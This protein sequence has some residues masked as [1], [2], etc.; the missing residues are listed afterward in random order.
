[1]PDNAKRDLLEWSTTRDAAQDLGTIL[2]NEVDYKA[3]LNPDPNII[4]TDDRPMNEY[5]LLRRLANPEL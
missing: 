4:I 1:M 5:F 3:D 2:S